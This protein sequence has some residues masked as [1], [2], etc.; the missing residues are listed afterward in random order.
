MADGSVSVTLHAGTV[1]LDGRGVLICGSSGSGKSGL[2]L[3]LMAL[4]AVLVADDH[5]LV[6]PRDGVLIASCPETI[7]GRIEARFVGI[8]KAVPSAPVPLALIV[9]LDHEEDQRL[10]PSR[11]R[12]VAGVPLP[13]LHNCAQRYFPAAI[14]QYLLHGRQ[15]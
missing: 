5:T 11:R 9:D 3:E 15:H 13:L 10:P 12:E 1:A 14:R 8:L 7:R 2:A 4:G 6:T